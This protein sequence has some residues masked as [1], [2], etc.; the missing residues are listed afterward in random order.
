VDTVLLSPCPQFPQHYASISENNQPAELIPQF[1]T[2]EYQ[3]QR[4]GQAPVIFLFVVDTCQDEDNLQALKESLQLSLSLVP[5]TALVGLITFGKMVQ[6]HELG[7]DGYAKSY[8]FRGSK[9]VGVKQ[10]QEQLGL[11]GGSGGRAQ[12]G[13]GPGPGQ[14]PQQQ[15]AARNRFLLPLQNIDMNLTDLIG[16]IQSDPWP[17]TLGMRPLRSTGVALSVAVGLLEA[18]FPNAGARILLFIGGSCTQ[19]PGMVVGEELKDPIRS[20]IDLDKDNANYSKKACK[21]YEALAKRAA[22]N[23]HCVD[24]YACALDQTGLHEM[25]YFS[26]LTGGHMVMGDSFNTTLFKQTWQKVFAK[27][28]H[29]QNFRMAFSA[30]FEVKCCRELKVCGVIGPCI[31]LNRRNQYVSESEVGVGGTAAWKICGLD[32][33]SSLAVVFEVSNQQASSIPQGQMGCLQFI[34]FYQHSTGQKRV[35]VTTIAR[36]WVDAATNLNHISSSFDQECA[37]V[38]MARLAVSRS[39]NDDGPDVLRWLDRMLI[40]LCQKFGEYHKDDPSSFKFN[41]NFSLYPQVSYALPF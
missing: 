33:S 16:D 41:E 32:P 20:H 8:V 28:A 12:A 23:G 39:E 29:G 21:H 9:D 3:L 15:Q 2:I 31:S 7:C 40:R 35:R 27:D 36:Q 37:A 11:A 6:L 13:S 1:S 14:Q 38:V 25:K 26:N 34:T 17:V 22:E 24:V 5:P 19:G 4:S 10:L 30:S 18:T